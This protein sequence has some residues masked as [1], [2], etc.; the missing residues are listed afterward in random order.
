MKKIDQVRKLLKAIAEGLPV[1]QYVVR[2]YAKVS[3]EDLL[4]SGQKEVEGQEIEKDKIYFQCI[5]AFHCANHYR[6]L[7]KA[8]DKGG[9][10]HVQ[11][12]LKPFVKADKQTEYFSK[13]K[14]VLC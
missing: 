4:L 10:W 2:D 8:Y 3:G 1:E 7:K 9:F 5:P 6:R 12:Y 13:L 11:I 14:E